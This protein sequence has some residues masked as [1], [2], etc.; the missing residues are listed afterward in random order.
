[1][2]RVRRKVVGSRLEREELLCCS[3]V[4]PGRPS[5]TPT[6]TIYWPESPGHETWIAPLSE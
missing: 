5:W 3:S 2:G 1:M 4:V 6:A